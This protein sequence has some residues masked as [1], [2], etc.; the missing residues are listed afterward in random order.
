MP[1]AAKIWP[2]GGMRSHATSDIPARGRGGAPVGRQCYGE[3]VA[4]SGNST[5]AGTLSSTLERY[6]PL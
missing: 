3:A 2:K 6:C 5:I 4:G 1:V